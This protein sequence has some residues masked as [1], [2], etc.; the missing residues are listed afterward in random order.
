MKYK[1]SICIPTLNRGSYIGETLESIVSQFE[2]GVEVVIVDGGST[3]ETEQVV[4]S[5]QDAFPSIRYLKKDSTEKNPSN[6]GFDRDC[7]H[8]VEQARGKYCW[9]MTDDDLL[10]PG[11]LRKVLSELEKSFALLVASVEVRNKDLTK[12]LTP[13]R[14]EYLNDQT[15]QPANW[16][17]FAAKVGRHLTF[18]GAVIID[19][20][21][22]L[23]R[24]REKYYGTGFVHVG[25][26]FDEPIVKDV[27]VIA[28]PLVTIRFG[29]AQWS[30][31]A[32]Q[33]WMFGWPELIWSFTTI[34]SEAKR[35]I[36]P[37]EPWKDF[38]TLLLERAFGTYSLREYELFLKQ[39]HLSSGARSLAIIAARF[40]Q[41][42]LLLL[43][44]LYAWVR[45][46]NS[47]MMIFNLKESWHYKNR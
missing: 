39:R 47:D 15:F 5:Y 35:A 8:A 20:E 24:N 29:N 2:D 36:T 37:K 17:E 6:E 45:P 42:I 30:N 32:F 3:D 11:A 44:F 1:L 38:K 46:S 9:L 33:I 27:L 14:P 19:R 43:A 40:P 25:A 41:T 13:R 16:N 34:S 4:N 12:V 26:I 21:L 22:W 7:N 31:R 10:M 23:S 18:V 28:A